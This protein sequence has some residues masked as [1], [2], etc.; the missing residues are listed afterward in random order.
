MEG[1]GSDALGR[2]RRRDEGGGGGGRARDGAALAPPARYSLDGQAS[3]G[4]GLAKKREG[5]G[6]TNPQSN[7][8]HRESPDLTARGLAGDMTLS[9][10]P[11]LVP[12]A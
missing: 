7:G 8:Q 2:A 5:R 10:S 9:V 6:Q 4:V 11:L 3:R 12:K 1:G